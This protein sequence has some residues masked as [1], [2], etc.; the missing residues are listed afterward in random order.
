MDQGTQEEIRPIYNFAEK[1]QVCSAFIRS[2]STF[3]ALGPL[4]RVVDLKFV[5]PMEDLRDFRSTYQDAYLRPY[6]DYSDDGV[7]EDF[8][9]LVGIVAGLEDAKPDVFRKAVEQLFTFIYHMR[10]YTLT[11]KEPFAV[12]P[13]EGRLDQISEQISELISQLEDRDKKITDVIEKL[14]L[15]IKTYGPTLNTADQYFADKVKKVEEGEKK[16]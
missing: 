11:D 7:K 4:K 12:T 9:W 1:L 5:I 8:D 16:N 14:L 3:N 10:R 6:K 15:L 13:I 2:K